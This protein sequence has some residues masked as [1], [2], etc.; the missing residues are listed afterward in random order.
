LH[1]HVSSSLFLL[2]LLNFLNFL[3]ILL[4]EILLC[5]EGD[6]FWFEILFNG[7]FVRR[8]CCFVSKQI[9]EKV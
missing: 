7:I 9:V 8:W 5:A 3:Y 4:I 6:W 1:Q 2:V